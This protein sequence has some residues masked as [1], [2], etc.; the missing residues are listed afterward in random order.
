MGSC[1]SNKRPQN[2]KINENTI[3][4][5]VILEYYKDE[6]I[7]D[8]SPIP[9]KE[10]A[11]Q[12]VSKETKE[13]EEK[14]NNN[15]NILKSQ[16]Q[17]QNEI[18]NPNPN[19]N[20]NQNSTNISN[21]LICPD[22]SKR[23]PHIEKLYYDNKSKDFLVKYTCICH[24]NYHPKKIP[25]I[26]ILSNKEPLNDCNIHINNKLTNYCKTC[27]RAICSICKEE[28]LNHELEND[29]IDKPISK[30]E[31]SKLLEIVKEKEKNFN[32]EINQNEEKMEN[33]IDNMIQKLNEEKISYKKQ[34]ENYKENN[35]KSFN[36]LKNL[37]ERYKNNID[38]TNE[39]NNN[40][41]NNNDIML[42]NHIQNF[43]IKNNDISKLNSNVD[44]IINQYNNG[45]KE[46]KLNY[47]YGF[48][49]NSKNS[50]EISN[51]INND[52]NDKNDKS[53]NIDNFD[54]C[55]KNEEN[56]ENDNI[57]KN[58]KK[59]FSCIKTLEGHSEKIVTLI[60]LSSGQIASGSYD[61]TIRI[62]DINT[63]KEEI[64][65]KEKGRVFCLL[66]FEK[67]KILSGTSDNSITL[68]DIDLPNEDSKYSF[69]GHELWVNS[70]VKCDDNYFASASNDKKIKIW[71]F[72]SKECIATL[73]GH[74][75]CVLY[76][77]ILKNKNLCSG[78]ADLTIKIWDWDEKVCLSTLKGHEKWVKCLLEL[79][80][81]IILS[82][83]DDNTI[84][85]WEKY[86]N[87]KTLKKHT[88]SVRTLCQ[89]NNY[90]FASGSFDCTI[91]IW[92]INNWK[93]VQIVVGHNNNIINIISIKN[94]N[95]Y[96]NAITSCSNDKTI[97]I[98][99]GNL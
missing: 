10:E 43:S 67:N 83:S 87:I 9:N 86:I 48:P 31:A 17:K 24:N 95:E 33:G 4:K 75:D 94:N 1:T 88:H 92:S 99:E 28:H 12:I 78:G 66:E 73:S 64:I 40:E 89:I 5:S 22:C 63:E 69:L 37:Y 6:P 46:L 90:Y 79:N 93:C 38:N 35:K 2:I 68:W 21:Y 57:Y 44:E 49:I 56:K 15:T 72:Y 65:I 54:K 53:D 11:K 30:E 20:Q 47:N 7:K 50:N 8:N 62:W 77:I 3:E 82:G 41:I 26:K 58:E 14:P 76:L 97:K 13:S 60:E 91:R 29:I 18:E 27:K 25:L 98:W 19:Q 71:D 51:Y 23:S 45:K 74:L 36:F 34:I 39:N 84:K 59:G 52:N 80:N 32:I 70:L 96:F 55:D 85:I 61:K 81:G 16:K 42:S